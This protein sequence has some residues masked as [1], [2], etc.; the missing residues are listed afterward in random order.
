MLADPQRKE[1]EASRT[2]GVLGL[3]ARGGEGGIMASSRD[4]QIWQQGVGGHV[5]ETVPTPP[6]KHQKG[7]SFL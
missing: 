4:G 6:P 5:S 3:Q 2:S 1:K 7:F